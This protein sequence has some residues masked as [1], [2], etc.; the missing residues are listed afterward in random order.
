[1]N[2]LPFVISILII[3]GI[4]VAALSKG[5]VATAV[6]KSA[7]EGYLN[8]HRKRWNHQEQA[9]YRKA[10]KGTA[11]QNGSS[12]EREEVADEE[13]AKIKSRYFRYR[14]CTHESGKFNLFPLIGQ[15]PGDPLATYLYEPAAELM[16][17]LYQHAPF[18]KREEHYEYQI[19]E[20]L[21]KKKPDASIYDLFPDSPKLARIFYL[22]QKG[23]NTYQLEQ[24]KGY[25]PLED[26]FKIEPTHQQ[27][28][29][30]NF[31]QAP[32]PTLQVFLGKELSEKIAL[33]EKGTNKPLIKKEFE[34]L[35]EHDPQK[36][37]ELQKIRLVFSDRE[38]A[39]S[40]ATDE[41]TG[42][43]VQNPR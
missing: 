3:L 37:A 22:V 35:V 1:M 25:P 12:S 40:V 26:F 7:I 28:F 20:A 9:F 8:A 32:L 38:L 42:I 29:V 5:H 34:S 41:R 13:E 17:T 14:R 30:L 10:P 24:G 6:E 27:V 23:T 4:G 18:W 31:Q 33:L 15:A 39:S 11:P 36:K 16:R 19:L 21:A 43:S 2:I